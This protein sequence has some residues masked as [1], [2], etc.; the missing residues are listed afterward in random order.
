[1]DYRYLSLGSWVAQPKCGLTYI[2][3]D[4]K[5]RSYNRKSGEV[6]FLP[7][8]MRKDTVLVNMLD[9]PLEVNN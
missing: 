6:L 4:Q 7:T 1:M 2:F 9:Y 8:P 5:T 3:L